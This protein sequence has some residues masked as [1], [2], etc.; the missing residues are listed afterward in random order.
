MATDPTFRKATAELKQL[1]FDGDWKDSAE[2]ARRVEACSEYLLTFRPTSSG[3]ASSSAAFDAAQLRKLLED[4]RFVLRSLSG[5]SA[6][7]AGS[8]SYLGVCPRR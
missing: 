8:I 1:L 4:A 5:S 2:K 6:G 7:G 3:H